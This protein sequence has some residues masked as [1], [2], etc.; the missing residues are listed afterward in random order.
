MAD[1]GQQTV[2]LGGEEYDVHLPESFAVRREL[3]LAPQKNTM[4]G[5]CALVG[6][7]LPDLRLSQKYEQHGFDPLAFGGDVWERCSKRG[8]SDPDI[9]EAGVTLYHLVVAL[10]YPDEAAVSGTVAFTSGTEGSPTSKPSTSSEHGDASLGG[11]GA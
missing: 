3:A 10:A 7:C 1:N 9:L 4:R 11:S 2:T 8:I 6:L 5:C